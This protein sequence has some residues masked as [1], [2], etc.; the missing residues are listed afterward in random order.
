M[1]VHVMAGSDILLIVNF[2]YGKGGG[3]RSRAIIKSPAFRKDSVRS[4]VISL[5]V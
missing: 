1:Q 2:D 3:G 4:E 5:V